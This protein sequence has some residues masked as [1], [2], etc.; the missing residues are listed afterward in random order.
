MNMPLQDILQRVSAA[1]N[2]SRF[3][4][5][6]AKVRDTA[7][8]VYARDPRVTVASMVGHAS[9]DMYLAALKSFMVFFC[10]ANVEAI[11]DGTLTAEDRAM[12]SHH[13]PQIHISH[14]RDVDTG[15]CPS[16][17]SWKRLF[18]IVEL[19]QSSYVVQL[20]SD[21]IT[22]G[23]MAEIYGLAM[24]NRGFMI[25]ESH[26]SRPIRTRHMQSIASRWKATGP[27]ARMEQVLAELPFFDEADTYL[28]GCA[29]FAGYPKGS[30]SRERVEALS[31]QIEGLIGHDNWHTWGS[32]QAISNCLI[33]KTDDA[34]TLPW[35][36]YRNHM[37]PPTNEPFASA[38]FIHFIGTHRFSDSVY[39]LAVERAIA[40]YSRLELSRPRAY[41]EGN[42]L[43]GNPVT[44]K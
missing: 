34:C 16:Y 31:L 39:R 19:S 7:P 8:L 21:T 37:F 23:A 25:G 40:H 33:S 5:A 10:D 26:W 13:V 17:S 4:R 30:L 6:N 2:R 35:P 27:Q 32:E 1:N 9:L 20:D 42:L 36:K 29:G 43:A 28:H 11:D 22:L 38:S 24:A 15:R 14:S 44:A 18:R 12:L 41:G 3:L